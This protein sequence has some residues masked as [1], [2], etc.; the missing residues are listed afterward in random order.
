[1]PSLVLCG[2]SLS[3]SVLL[4]SCFL[5]SIPW[6]WHWPSLYHVHCSVHHL[7]PTSPTPLCAEHWV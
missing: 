1:L 7:S 3:L 2:A 5:F 6:T 4:I